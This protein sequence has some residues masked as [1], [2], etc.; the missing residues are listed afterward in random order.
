[1]SERFL[2]R[3]HQNYRMFHA[4]DAW[5]RAHVA[6]PGALVLAGLLVTAVLGVD[7]GVTLAHQVFA[8][9]AVLSLAAAAA[10]VFA[11]PR[12][13][14]VRRLP[15]HATVGVPVRYRLEVRNLSARPVAGLVLRERWPDPRPPV[16]EFLRRR[17][18]LESRRNWVDRFYAFHRWGWLVERRRRAEGGEARIDAIPPRGKAEAQVTMTP[19]RRGAI[20]LTAVAA[21]APDLFGLFHGVREARAPGRLVV[22]PRRY[23]VPRLD[24]PGRHR[25][26]Q[27]GGVAM[28]SSVGES[29]EFISLRDYRP[30]DPPRHIHWRSWARAGR[31]IVKE[32]QNEFF[33]RH[34][35]VLDTFAGDDDEDVFEEAVSVAASFACTLPDRDA[36]L[37]LLFIGPQAFCFTAGRGLAHAEQMLGILAAVGRCGDRPFDT[38]G[39]LVLAHA[40]GISGAIC[41]MTRW[42]A[43]RR[44]L[45]EALAAQG[46]P[47]H[48]YIVRKAGAPPGSAE[49]S[50]APAGVG[51][52][53]L[54]CGRIAEGLAAP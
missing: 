38:L 9:L 54:E 21:G 44:A 35:L 7:T 8:L 40:A 37:D 27:P 23:P 30:G 24:L 53:W 51:L 22:L 41:V 34:A 2:R 52:R 20:G 49:D 14:V 42:D 3:Q 16:E 10:A 33:V 45:V 32:F 39:R 28:A 26:Y 43:P 47:A 50:T 15:R 31:P 29:G 36:L 4:S 1:M 12:I 18:P 13:E 5:L 17:E 46:V 48:V 6:P 25:R 11:R 19:L